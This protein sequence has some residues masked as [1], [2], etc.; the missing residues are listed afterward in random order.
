MTSI[1]SRA[2]VEDA[3]EPSSRNYFKIDPQVLS[4]LSAKIV[5][6][7]LRIRPGENVA[8]ETWNHGLEVAKELAFQVKKAGAHPL[9]LFEDEPNFWRAAKEL[10]PSKLG[11]V[12]KHEWAV[13]Q[14]A[15]AYLFIPGPENE[16]MYDE[17]PEKVGDALTAYNDEW[18]QRALKYR[19]R[20]LRIGLGYM[21]R[22]RAKKFGL[23]FDDW[24]RE[25][26][27]AFDTD[28]QK[29]DRIGTRLGNI[30]KNGKKIEIVHSNGTAL[31]LEIKRTRG[32][33]LV[34]TGVKK[35]PNAPANSHKY[36]VLASLPSGSVLCV[37][38][39]DSA[40]GVIRFNLPTPSDD[41]YTRDVY[42]RFGRTGGWTST[43]V[44]KTLRR[45]SRKSMTRR[46][47]RTREEPRSS[48]LDSIR[49][50]ES[51]TILTIQVKESSCSG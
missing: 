39:E 46:K 45:T 30:L 36:S 13:V 16:D 51:A 48:Q 26:L 28:Y 1:M 6:E 38:K 15:D 4:A 12:G 3:E 8:I 10:S 17:F 25:E 11:K 19:I 29:I 2:T 22:G 23:D 32:T 27:K 20:G 44:G 31:E 35:E 18:Y 24:V 42:F 50:K 43:Q 21:N 7:C 33:P 40:T 34:D 37:P 5:K 9:L 41:N 47:N 14:N 49:S